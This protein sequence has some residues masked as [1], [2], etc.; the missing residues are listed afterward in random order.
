LVVEREEGERERGG[1]ME[2]EETDGKFVVV[3][4]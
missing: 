4:V 1:V 3:D 2:E